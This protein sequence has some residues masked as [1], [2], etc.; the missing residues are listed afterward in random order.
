MPVSNLIVRDRADYPDA[1]QARASLPDIYQ[2]YPYVGVW[3]QPGDP[4]DCTMYVFTTLDPDTLRAE[5]WDRLEEPG[6]GHS[7]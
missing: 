1:E 6:R 7:G 5:G 4:A 3:L 2:E